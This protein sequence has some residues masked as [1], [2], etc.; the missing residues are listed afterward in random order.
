MPIRPGGSTGGESGMKMWIYLVRRLILLV[1]VIIGVMT[2]TFVI[3]ASLP[4][5]D[6]LVSHF[7]T[8]RIPLTPTVDCSTLGLGNGTCRNPVYYHDLHQLGL[9]KPKYVQWAIYMENSLTLNWGASDAGS[10]ASGLLLGAS[11]IPIA[12][13]LSWYLPYTLEL[14]AL[15]LFL[16]LV[17]AIPLGNYSAVYRNRPVDQAA[18]LMSF[19]GFALPGFLLA[20]LLLLGFTALLSALPLE[21]GNTYFAFQHLYNSWPPTSCGTYSWMGSHGQTSPTG[22]PTVDAIYHGQYALAGDTL[23]RLILPAVTIAYGSIAIILRFVRNSM[24]EVM[25]LDFVRT[26]RAKG[27]P[28]SA[29]VRKH[30]GRNSLN[31]TVTILGLTFAG[32]IGGFPIIEDVFHLNGVGLLLTYSIQPQFDFGLIFGSVL[33]FTIIVVAANIIVDVLY[34]YLDPRVRLG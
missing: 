26:A 24:L 3:T 25:N 33:L 19:S 27:V 10:K 17:L 23:V 22:F 2:I 9:D 5:H 12:E 32:F 29:V 16:I 20:S 8:G 34:A 31:V 13:V 30:A 4:V 21:C 1:P 28:E 7:G 14:A 11:S 6:Q 18:R 15:S